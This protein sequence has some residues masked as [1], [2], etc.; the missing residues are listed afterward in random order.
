MPIIK[1][2]DENEFIG[3]LVF[4]QDTVTWGGAWIGIERHQADNKLYWIDDTLVAGGFT[5]WEAGNP[6]D[7]GGREDCGHIMG[8]VGPG[9]E[10]QNRKW[11][12]LH[13]NL[14]EHNFINNYPVILCEKSI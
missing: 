5:G 4:A 14:V 13:C 7:K 9:F 10:H 2:E 6:S 3:D 11:N 8:Q 12:D 1:S